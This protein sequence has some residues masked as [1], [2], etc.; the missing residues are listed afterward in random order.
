MLT[1]TFTELVL[2]TYFNGGKEAKYANT[3]GSEVVDKMYDLKSINN[4]L[5]FQANSLV[6]YKSGGNKHETSLYGLL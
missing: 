4:S 1:T 5:E 2:K 3:E 6:W